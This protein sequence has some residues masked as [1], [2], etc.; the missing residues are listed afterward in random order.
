MADDYARK[1]TE[2]LCD[3][4]DRRYFRKASLAHLK[5]KT[6]EAGSQATRDWIAGHVKSN[7][8]YRL[9]KGSGIRPT[10]TKERKELLGDTT[11]SFLDTPTGDHLADKVRK[12]EAN[13]CRR[14]D[15]GDS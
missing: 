2:S 11:S 5:R 8:Q 4:T 7:R 13:K 12:I 1:A 15:G 9:P 10:L 14:W 3:V 6:T